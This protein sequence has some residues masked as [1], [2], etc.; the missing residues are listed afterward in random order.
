MRL[1]DRHARTHGVLGAPGA[2]Y[3]CAQHIAC[4]KAHTGALAS[5]PRGSHCSQCHPR[6]LPRPPSAATPWQP[7]HHHCQKPLFVT[8]RLQQHAPTASQGLLQGLYAGL[9]AAG[10][11]AGTW[12]GLLQR[13]KPNKG[14]SA[15]SQLIEQVRGISSLDARTQGGVHVHAQHFQQQ[16]TIHAVLAW[17]QRL[18]SA[19]RC[20]ISCL[21]HG[22]EPHAGPCRQRLGNA[23]MTDMLKRLGADHHVPGRSALL[24][25]SDLLKRLPGCVGGCVW[26]ICHKEVPFGAQLGGWGCPHRGMRLRAPHMKHV[27]RAG[28]HCNLRAPHVA[29]AVLVL[30]GLLAP[31][32]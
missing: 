2:A 11:A 28:C 32:P 25:C 18:C 7:K 9:D 21:D 23:R 6:S 10:G 20:F 24:G 14:N 27:Q 8:P 22:H 19:P 16:R 3:H 1:S 31:T 4:G 26:L 17:H 30:V 12:G 15:A 5:S 13:G 29:S